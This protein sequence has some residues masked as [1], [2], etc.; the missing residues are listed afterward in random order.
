MNTPRFPN[1]TNKTWFWEINA[2][3]QNSLLP[4][5][6]QVASKSK[7]VSWARKSS[8]SVV[9]CHWDHRTGRWG[10]LIGIGFPSSL[11]VSQFL[12]HLITAFPHSLRLFCAWKMHDYASI[13]C[14]LKGKEACLDG[15]SFPLS[16][17]GA[18]KEFLP[19]L[20]LS[21]RLC[22]QAFLPIKQVSSRA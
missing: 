21:P 11:T 5:L 16:A 14:F 18:L 6:D 7:M 13:P 19:E 9:H 15:P 4:K 10:A 22:V 1:M 2:H 20:V 8:C 3:T 12:Q 17:P